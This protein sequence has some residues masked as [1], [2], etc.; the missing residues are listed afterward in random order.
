MQNFNSNLWGYHLPVDTN[1]AE[2][3]IDGNNRRI[4]CHLPIGISIHSALMPQDGA[5][6]ILINKEL[7][8]KLGIQEGDP[9]TVDIEKDE[10]EFGIPMPESFLVLLDQD[11]AGKIY[12]NQLTPGKQRSLLYIISKVKNVDSQIS[13]GLAILDH[14]KAVKG[15][16]DYKMLNATIKEYNQRN[17]LKM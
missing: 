5:Y 6:F 1:F 8:N 3:F 17:K 10:S 9:I 12:F 15:K 2:Q 16:I 11:E 7:R 14:L 4:I 13:K